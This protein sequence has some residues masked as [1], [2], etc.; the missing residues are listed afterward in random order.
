MIKWRRISSS[1]LV[2]VVLLTL[3]PAA[4]FAAYNDNVYNSAYN[5]DQAR[6]CWCV[7]AVARTWLGYERPSLPGVSQTD[8]DDYIAYSN[9]HNHHDKYDWTTTPEPYWKCADGSYAHDSRGLAWAMYH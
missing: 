8:I 9:S 7:V 5:K 2:T 4:A 6:R 1:L 3:H